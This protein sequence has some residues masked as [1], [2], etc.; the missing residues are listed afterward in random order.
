MPAAIIP[1]RAADIISCVQHLPE[2]H[3]PE[4]GY[5]EEGG[6]LHL[7]GEATFL[8]AEL[9]LLRRLSVEGICRPGLSKY[10]VTTASRKRTLNRSNRLCTRRDLSSRRQIVVRCPLVSYRRYRHDDAA[11]GH[12]LVGNGGDQLSWGMANSG[13]GGV[14]NALRR[15]RYFDGRFLKAGSSGGGGVLFRQDFGAKQGRSGGGGYGGITL[16]K[17]K[18]QS[19]QNSIR[20]MK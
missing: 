7:D 10:V 11:G 15:P 13:G 12:I 19:A 8:P 6:C 14:N 2:G 1:L 17:G 20:N 18:H 9:H 16:K 4:L 5:R 3:S